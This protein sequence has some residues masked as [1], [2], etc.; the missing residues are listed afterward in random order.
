MFSDLNE[1]VIVP[2]FN[3]PELL[4]CCL[5]RIREAEPEI[6][7]LVFP[8][9]G[10]WPLY[11]GSIDKR[12]DVEVMM[13]PD[14]PWHGNTSNTM[15]AFRFAYNGGADVVYYI[16]DDV[17]IHPNFFAWHR[18]QH[19]YEGNKLFGSMGWVFNQHAPITND[20]LYQPWYYAIGTCF[21]RPKLRLIVEHASPLYYEYMRDYIAEKFPLS[22]LNSPFGIEHYE[23]DGLIQ[24][25]ME[26]DKSQTVAAGI[27]CCSHVGAFGY[28]RGWTQDKFFA[29]CKDFDARVERI[30]ILIKDPYWR[31]QLF[32]RK[33][34]EREIGHVLAP[35]EFV[36]DIRTPDGWHSKF[37]SELSREALPTRIN[38]VDL[39]PG[40]TIERLG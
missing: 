16:E 39:P 31:A 14:N 40:T 35:R 10:T 8:D 12:F 4:H 11:K 5:K 37:F 9:R 19:G 27:A 20:L 28:N 22:A 29:G 17:M 30:E 15:E 38:S 32:G 24:R 34:V 21:R 2:T 33:L 13:V 1:C 23:Q 7:V 26:R 6:P 18:D 3:R 25:V 36:Y